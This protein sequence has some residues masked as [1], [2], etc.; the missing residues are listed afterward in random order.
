MTGLVRL[1]GFVGCLTLAAP[2]PAADPPRT[3]PAAPTPEEL[4]RDLGSPLFPVREKATKALWHLG[5]KAR[6]A[7]TAA[8]GSPD[9]EVAE[10]AQEILEKFDWGIFPD[11]PAEVLKQIREFRSGQV[12]KQQA[13]V[14]ALL[15]LGD[16][17]VPTLRVLLVKEMPKEERAAVFEHLCHTL[18][19]EVPALLFD[20][21]PDR[22]E[23]LLALNALGP[24][25]SGL[26]D[27]SVFLHLRGRAKRAA[28]ELEAA[29]KTVGPPG[30]AAANA[31]VFVYRA[32]GDAAKAKAV[33]KEL[34]DAG[35]L[36]QPE[37]RGSTPLNLYDSLLED[38]GAWG[39]LADRP[40]PRANSPDGL[41]IFRLRLAGRQKEADELT[42]RQKDAG[43]S[44][45]GAGGVDE[46]T[47][48][49]ML[50][51]RPLDGIDRLKAHHNA[52]HILADLLS[53]RLRFKDALD[54]LGGSDKIDAASGLDGS[55][56][57]QLYG[58]R[59]GRLLAQLGQRDAAAQ[60]FGRLADQLAGR[61]S[62]ALTQLI[63]AE[64]RSGRFDLAC[65]HLGR[66][67]GAETDHPGRRVVLG[68]QDP[69]ESLFDADAD[70]AQYW[71]RVLRQAR[72]ADES[73]GATM[74][75]V[76]ALLTGT[77][78]AAELDHA[79]KAA[80]HS[81][82]PPESPEG[83]TRALALAAAYRSAGKPDKAVAELV[84][85]ADKLVGG[86]G[87]ADPSDDGRDGGA[88]AWVFGIDERF[89]FWVELGDLLAEQGRFK[90]AAARLE[91]G[92]RWYPEN[93]VLLYLSG[94]ALL[95]AGEEKEGRRRTDL[96]HWVGLGNARVRG[97]FLDELISRGALADARRERDLAREAGWVSELYIGN[98]WNQV[99]RASVLLK[100]FDAA[101]SAHRRAIHYLLRNYGVSYVEGYAYLTVPQAVRSYTARGL[102][103]AGKVGEAVALA[104]DCL[105]VMPGHTELVIG[106]VPGLDR[107]G[108]KKEAD[109]LFRLA[110]DAYGAIVKEHPD[111][112]WARYS[113]A[114]LAAGCRRELPAALEHA[115]KAVELEPGLRPYKEALAE[116]HFRRGE[117]EQAVA[118]MKE[119]AAADRRNFHYKRQLERYQTGD[120][121][122]PLPDADDD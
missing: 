9:A 38:V 61:D 119:L 115:K 58:T 121:A 82:P 84:K 4:V 28:A 86:A 106:M 12:Q 16:P 79:V 72:P 103:A 7:L 21:K 83:Q 87:D 43:L 110:W 30:D 27:Y 57:R 113:A 35:K 50:N 104:K 11:T 91:Q 108:R 75:L 95:K 44:E 14:S 23:A 13:A 36:I 109:E 81:V 51:G 118:L 42:D 97:R 67:L 78:T 5:E 62:A 92:W 122:S 90:E 24:S 112:A 114:W 45:H 116:V 17:A 89:R 71:W 60:L 41:K 94:R 105:A 63:R 80:G 48:A 117:R 32:A 29:R 25:V 53:Q 98:V 73:P 33:A 47:V 85:V 107:L 64:V 3:A 46:A 77:A 2:A 56:L 19:R 65:E 31:L 111:S 34:E 76:R 39:E 69:F 55:Y 66:A 40:A 88:R 20:G 102:L 93:G 52:P 120:P 99:A 101:A 6:P 15:K 26:T 22:A 100:D 49:L 59:R 54:L 96:A 37:Q 10:R 18:R 8:L 68:S 1:A 74:R 70:A